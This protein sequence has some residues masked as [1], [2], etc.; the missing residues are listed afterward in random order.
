MV[1]SKGGARIFCLRGANFGTNIIVTSQDKS[2]H[3][4]V[5]SHTYTD[6]NINILILELIIIYKIYILYIKLT[7][8]TYVSS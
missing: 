6:I 1:T 7:T 4:C 2:S 5:N 8:F 3:I